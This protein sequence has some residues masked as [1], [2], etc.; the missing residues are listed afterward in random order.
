MGRK[1]S[2]TAEASCGPD[3]TDERIYWPWN[4]KTEGT[5]TDYRD[6]QNAMEIEQGKEDQDYI[7]H[8]YEQN[9]NRRWRHR[10]NRRLRLWEAEE[11]IAMNK[12]DFDAAG[13]FEA[14]ASKKA[15]ICKQPDKNDMPAE[16]QN[17]CIDKTRLSTSFLN[18]ASELDSKY[19]KHAVAGTK[20]GSTRLI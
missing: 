8:F 12:Q 10:Q 16:S 15:R 1:I 7:D 14:R 9:A 17:T 11:R 13:N 19:P 6:L 4:R 5:A 18:M 2:L 3:E 20:F